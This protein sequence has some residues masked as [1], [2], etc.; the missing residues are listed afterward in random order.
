MQMKQTMIIVKNYNGNS[1]Y[2]YDN[3]TS[4]AIATF[5]LLLAC[6]CSL[7]KSCS[8]RSP[9]KIVNAFEN[10]C[11]YCTYKLLRLQQQ[12][13]LLVLHSVYSLPWIILKSKTYPKEKPLY[14]YKATARDFFPVQMMFLFK[15]LQMTTIP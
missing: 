6:F 14:M 1:F 5:V 13:Q 15:I 12:Q 11:C 3:W 7:L 9:K 4:T 2:Y 8:K 10:C